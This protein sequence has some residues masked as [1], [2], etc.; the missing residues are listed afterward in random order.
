MD[1]SKHNVMVNGMGNIGTTLVNLLL[2]YKS[3][4]FLD[5][6]YVVKRSIHPWNLAERTFLEKMGAIICT[7]ND[8]EG[9][10]NVA[11]IINEVDYIFEATTNGVA[12]SFIARSTL[13]LLCSS[14]LT[15]SVWPL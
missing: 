15:T 11:Y 5:K 14:T 7:T 1:Q 8:K 9:L 4:L 2:A 6:I 10:T 3:D 12:P 13:A